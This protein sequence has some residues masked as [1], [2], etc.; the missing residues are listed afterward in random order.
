MRTYWLTGE[1]HGDFGLPNI[2]LDP[3]RNLLSFIDAGTIDTCRICN[4]RSNELVAERE[5]AHLLCS[6]PVD[7]SGFFAGS[8]VRAIHE[9]F[10]RTF[11]ITILESVDTPA[12]R[13][14]LLNGIWF[15]SQTHLRPNVDTPW[16]L[17][18]VWFRFIREV[19]MYRIRWLLRRVEEQSG[20]FFK[21]KSDCL[22]AAV[23]T[24]NRGGA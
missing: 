20:M 7:L 22:I 4:D 6:V 10:V 5:I 18:A 14:I 24:L 1:R 11:L 17:R 13:R 9:I 15:W 21:Q 16:S 19:A 3:E 8:R 12:E 2:L 23:Q